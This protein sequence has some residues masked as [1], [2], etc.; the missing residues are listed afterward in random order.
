VGPAH[1]EYGKGEQL[2]SSYRAATERSRYA[3]RICVV[4]V[5]SWH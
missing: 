3:T 5:V 1:S 2:Q 4:L